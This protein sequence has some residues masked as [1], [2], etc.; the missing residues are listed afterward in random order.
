MDSGVSRVSRAG[1]GLLDLLFPPRCPTCGRLTAPGSREFCSFCGKSTA[2]AGR[3]SDRNVFY[4]EAYAAYVFEGKIRDLVLDLKFHGKREN[5]RPL[6]QALAACIAK[7]G[8]RFD[9]ISWIPVS[10]SR[11]KERGYDQAGLIAASAAGA[12]G[13]KCTPTLRR[14]KST[15]PNSRMDSS[16]DRKR[17]VSGAFET[18]YDIAGKRIVLIDD[19]IS[20]GATMN[21][22]AR[23]LK[24]SGAAAVTAAAVCSAVL[25]QQ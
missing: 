8:L 24:S 25:R 14:I 12:L 18:I 1:K 21:E 4:D 20:S 13:H 15:L 9:I 11:L 5:A 17:N 16:S 6:G 3:R 23:V 10:A 2:P 7:N 22:C 19:V